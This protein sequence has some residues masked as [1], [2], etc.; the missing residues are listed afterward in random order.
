M[1]VCFG[2]APARR[3]ELSAEV[4]ALRRQSAAGAPDAAEQ[5]RAAA[6]WLYAAAVRQLLKFGLATQVA[7]GAVPRQT[8]PHSPFGA[9]IDRACAPALRQTLAGRLHEAMD[10]AGPRGALRGFAAGRIEARCVER[11][12]PS[13]PAMAAVTAAPPA[14]FDDAPPMDRRA[15]QFRQRSPAPGACR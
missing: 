9:R 1:P 10:V 12:P 4:S 14:A 3:A 15:P 11:L 2:E 8:V 6:P 5:T 7:L 13:P